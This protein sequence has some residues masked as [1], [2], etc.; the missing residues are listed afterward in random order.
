MQ[1]RAENPDLIRA[2][3]KAQRA[4][5]LDEEDEVVLALESQAILVDWFLVFRLVEDGV[6]EQSA[7]PISF[8]QDFAKNPGFSDEWN[9][10]KHWYSAEFIQ[11]LDSNIIDH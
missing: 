4:E 10:T 2:M 6:I 8:W 1:R 7:I 9:K 5:E 11:Y 3:A